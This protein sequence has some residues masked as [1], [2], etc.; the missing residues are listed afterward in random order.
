MQTESRCY[1]SL[2]TEKG[3]HNIHPTH[4]AYIMVQRVI[5]LHVAEKISA[6][7][8]LD[9]QVIKRALRHLH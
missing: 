6:E 4:G 2:L 8:M 5:N 7:G 9:P 3:H 1:V